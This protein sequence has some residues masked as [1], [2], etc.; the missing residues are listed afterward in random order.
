M[1]IQGDFYVLMHSQLQGCFHIEKAG[2]M[3]DKNVRIYLRGSGADFIPLMFAATIDELLEFK[4][5]L[6]SEKEKGIW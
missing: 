3:L 6:I 5:Q 1:D 2:V 4:A